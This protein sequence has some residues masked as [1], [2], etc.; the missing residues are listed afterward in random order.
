MFTVNA[1]RLLDSLDE[2]E[3]AAWCAVDGWEATDIVNVN[4]DATLLTV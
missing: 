1:M 2:G 4:W 3:R